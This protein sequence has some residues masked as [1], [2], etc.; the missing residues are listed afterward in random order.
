[1]PKTIYQVDAFTSE[2]FK[3]NPAGVMILTEGLDT[4]LM[5]NIA[6]EMNLSETAFVDI[7]KKPFE[8]RFFTPTTEIPLCGHATLASAHVLYAEGIV[9]DTDRID[10]TSQYGNLSVAKHS[11]GLQMVFPT[12]EFKP[13][14]IPH[15]FEEIVG[16]TPI[17]TYSTENN[18]LIAIAEHESDIEQAKPVFGE[19][20]DNG[21]GHLMITS[22]SDKENIDFVVRCFVPEIGIDEDPVTGSAQC[23]L[24][25]LWHFKTGKAAFNV[26]Q[27]SKRT[28]LLNVKLADDKV[29]IIGEAVTV[30]KAELQ[31]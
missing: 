10:L 6:M 30:F 8:I 21:L 1:M 19:M 31:L 11:K 24:V 12:Y 18:W 26:E 29:E 16:F 3:G 25:P 5:Q 9:K 15:R 22:L 4:Q 7:S 13:M 28:G 17:E 2:T 23:G 14:D 27:I 20:A